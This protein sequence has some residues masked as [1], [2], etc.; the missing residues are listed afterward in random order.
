MATVPKFAAVREA[1]AERLRA[2]TVGQRLPSER[3][4]VA[5]FGVSRV[6][7]RHALD[8][9]AAAGLL[10]REHGRG[11]F[12]AATSSPVRY[13]ERFAD[14]L[15]GFH[16]QQTAEGHRV[17]SLVDGWAVSPASPEAARA[18]GLAP[19]AA[20]LELKRRRRVNGSLHH[21]AVAH[22]PAAV[23]AGLTADDLADASLLALLRQR[24]GRAAS[25]VEVAVS[26]GSA[27]SEVAGALGLELGSAILVAASTFYD[28]ADAP[29]VR[30]IA[31]FAPNSSRLTFGIALRRA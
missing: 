5:E 23:A 10:R 12:V 30:S 7:L 8:D 18:L 1:L 17:T 11:T 6:T 31:S 28:Q 22:V 21:Y 25:R 9:L 4:L 2:M 16:D 13:P 3:A 27:D 19:G 14:H 26:L 15:T 24:R 29:L 20:V